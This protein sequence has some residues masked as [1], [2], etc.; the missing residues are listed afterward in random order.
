MPRARPQSPERDAIDT[1]LAKRI[2]VFDTQ[3][4]TFLD[5][6]LR[7]VWTYRLPTGSSISIKAQLLSPCTCGSQTSQSERHWH[8]WWRSFR[9]A[10]SISPKA[11]WTFTLL[12]HVQTLRTYSTPNSTSLAR[13]E[14]RRV[15][16]ECR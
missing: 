15:G 3:G 13:S 2:S 6:F 10:A 16:K 8:P 5:S 4:Q 9:N 1:K 14:E 11:W 7:L 12:Q